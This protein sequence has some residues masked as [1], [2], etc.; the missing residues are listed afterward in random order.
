MNR[1]VGAIWLVLIAGLVTG[2]FH[3]K[4]EVQLLERRLAAIDKTA[5]DDRRAIGVLEAEWTYLNRPE[6]LARLA[7]RYLRLQQVTPNNVRVF[8]ELPYR[9]GPAG[10][11]EQPANAEASQ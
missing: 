6:R 9:F 8:S 10:M 5:A 1:A 2:L 4:Q 7:K 11:I 3:F